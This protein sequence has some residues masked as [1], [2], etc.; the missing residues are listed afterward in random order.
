[1]QL[2]VSVLQKS[3]VHSLPSSQL[4]GSL[5]QCPDLVSQ[6]SLVHALPSLH[7]ELLVS[8]CRLQSP[9]DR[10]AAGRARTT[11]LDDATKR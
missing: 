7:S 10:V 2:P 11:Q 1:M 3:S 6:R 9:Y 4:I 5:K 8:D